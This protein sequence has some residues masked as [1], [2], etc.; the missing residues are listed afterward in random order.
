[1]KKFIKFLFFVFICG[2]VSNSHL[3][4]PK[5]DNRSKKEM[6]FHELPI[7]IKNP[8]DNQIKLKSL[9]LPLIEVAANSVNSE[10]NP[11]LELN[12]S[13][14]EIGIN[15][16]KFFTL[17]GIIQTGDQLSAMLK[18]SDGLNLIKEGEN[19]NKNLK[20]KKISLE[21]ETVIF[22][23]GENEFKLEFSEK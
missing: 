12:K 10:R 2:L 17:T 1:M 18:S 3:V 7:K 21:N 9:P 13:I 20:I 19:I 22:T 8:K 6:K 11:F 16:K 14:E 23:D 15:P 4:L 5:D